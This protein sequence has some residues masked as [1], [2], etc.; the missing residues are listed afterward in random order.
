MQTN[1][2][3]KLKNKIFIIWGLFISGVILVFLIILLLAMNKPQTKTD[4]QNKPTLT[5]KANLQQ[6]QETYNA[7]ISKIEKEIDKLTQQYPPKT[8]YQ[9]D[10]ITPRSYEIYDSK[11]KLIKDTYYKIDGKTIKYIA[12]HDKDTNIMTKSTYYLD[13]GKTID[14]I[15]EYTPTGIFIKT[16]YYNPDGTVKEII[17]R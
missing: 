2:Q 17:N 3:K 8:T 6:E 5:S 12:E 14:Y 11:G 9:K 7:I 4:N 1:N 16:T 10:G 13:D 15:N